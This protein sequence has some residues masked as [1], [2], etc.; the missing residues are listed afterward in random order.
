MTK[1]APDKTGR[2]QGK[3]PA[4]AKDPRRAPT[5]SEQRA[6]DR[7]VSRLNGNLVDPPEI[8]GLLSNGALTLASPHNNDTGHAAAVVD[9]V[10]LSGAV[11][12]GMV[13]ANLVNVTGR[14]APT[15]DAEAAAAAREVR[16]GVAFIQS[17]NPTN[18]QE[19]LMGLHMWIS[20]NATAMLS[21]KLHRAQELPQFAAYASLLNKSQRTFA[22]QVET[23]Q[24]LRTGGKQQVEV[25]YVYVDART[26][27]VVAGGGGQPGTFPQPQARLGHAP[28]LP[29]WSEDAGGDTLPVSGSQEPEAVPDAR[30]Q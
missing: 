18:S 24:K 25:R 15:T 28:G 19:A 23:L 3:A 13:Q 7:A 5:E 17:L 30:G 21:R 1:R 8:A 4:P 16:E 6:I 20:H 10:G 2:K 22:A 27:T 14:S 9:A 26:Q 29:V 11:L 12:A